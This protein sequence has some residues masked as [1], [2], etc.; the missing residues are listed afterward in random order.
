MQRLILS[1]PVNEFEIAIDDEEAGKLQTIGDVAEIYRYPKPIASY[2]PTSNPRAD[3]EAT[4][5]SQE[6][7]EASR[8]SRSA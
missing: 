2:L 8:R 6:S 7:N 1:E 5:R 4:D 3:A